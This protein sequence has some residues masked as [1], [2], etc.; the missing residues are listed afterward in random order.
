MKEFTKFVGYV[1][2]ITQ[3][4]SKDAEKDA[5]FKQ[6]DWNEDGKLS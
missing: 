4:K 5:L 3:S 1:D 6:L 2:G